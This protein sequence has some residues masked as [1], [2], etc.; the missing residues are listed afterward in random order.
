MGSFRKGDFNIL[1]ATSV[2]EAGLDIQKCNLVIRT[3]PPST[4]IQNIQG[5]GRARY[6]GARYIV[7]CI[8][9][10]EVEDLEKL[11]G[12]ENGLHSVLTASAAARDMRPA[13]T[14][15]SRFDDE[16]DA[17]VKSKNTDWVSML[18]I[19][20]QSVIRPES[21][22]LVCEYSFEGH[23]PPH[24]PSFKAIVAVGG[25]PYEGR[26]H[27]PTKKQAKQNA[28]AYALRCLRQDSTAVQHDAT[29]A[30]VWAFW[31]VRSESSEEEEGR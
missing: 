26:R 19:F 1:V 6:P 23:G 10:T 9:S 27:C 20:L 24:E 17:A 4:V 25:H 28:A 29:S 18:N 16:G 12:D 2:A 5:R 22:Q 21:H 31:D 3:E 13:T 15:W 14:S 11:R 30:G 7:I 8:D